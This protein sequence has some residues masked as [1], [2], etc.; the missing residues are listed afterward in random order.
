MTKKF[1]YPLPLRVQPN[2][3]WWY[4]LASLLFWK[5]REPL[6][7]LTAFALEATK[8][9]PELEVWQSLVYCT[10][11][12]YCQAQDP[13]SKD[14]ELKEMNFAEPSE[15]MIG[16]VWGYNMINN[17][18]GS[19]WNTAQS[20]KSAQLKKHQRSRFLALDIPQRTSIA[21][22]SFLY[23]RTNSIII[24]KRWSSFLIAPMPV[25]ISLDKDAIYNYYF[26]KMRKFQTSLDH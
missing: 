16:R 25:P 4:S 5:M 19:E 8:L 24:L 15:R 13:R 10:S 23:I 14:H 12:G 6:L 21:T 1:A 2:P 11:T 18:G 22:G 26:G 3:S 17:S 7:F 20:P 9:Q